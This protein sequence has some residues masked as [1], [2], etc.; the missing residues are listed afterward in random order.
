M[1]RPGFVVDEPNLSSCVA[2]TTVFAMSFV[3]PCCYCAIRPASETHCAV[4]LCV[5]GLSDLRLSRC[6]KVYFCSRA[7]LTGG[8][9]LSNADVSEAVRVA[10]P[11]VW[12]GVG[13]E[14]KLCCV[15][16]HHAR[17]LAADIS[18]IR[19]QHERMRLSFGGPS[20]SHVVVPQHF[21]SA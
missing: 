9:W 1:H 4:A 14:P 6:E 12:D 3:M 2:S 13:V 11:L 16:L 10:F 7:G 19:V 5:R 15:R 18:P 17:C 8:M 20:S 21:R